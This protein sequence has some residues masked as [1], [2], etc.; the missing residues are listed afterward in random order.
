MRRF[1]EVLGT[2]VAFIVYG[3]YRLAAKLRG[4]EPPTA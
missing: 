4:G 1:G 3:V 2:I